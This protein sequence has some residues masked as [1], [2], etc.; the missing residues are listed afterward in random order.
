MPGAFAETEVKVSA[1]DEG[2]RA[3]HRD[4]NLSDVVRHIRDDGPAAVDTEIAESAAGASQS[5]G[6]QSRPKSAAPDSPP[7]ILVEPLSGGAARTSGR[8]GM[9]VAASAAVVVVL[10]GL[11]LFFAG[12][13]VDI[14][15]STASERTAP[16]APADQH[17]PR[18]VAVSEAS[19]AIAAI[20]REDHER[21]RQL[22]ALVAQGNQADKARIAE[23]EE[24]VKQAQAALAA[25]SHRLELVAR[26]PKDEASVGPDTAKPIAP[27]VAANGSPSRHAGAVQQ[28][29]RGGPTRGNAAQPQPDALTSAVRSIAA[30][31]KRRIAQALAK[32]ADS[33]SSGRARDTEPA[34]PA[35]AVAPPGSAPYGAET[36]VVSAA[37]GDN[38]PAISK[39]EP[40]GTHTGGAIEGGGEPS[41]I[42]AS[43]FDRP[44]PTEQAH[45][46]PA[47]H[48]L[49][50]AAAEAMGFAVPKQD[51]SGTGEALGTAGLALAEPPSALQHKAA[52]PPESSRH[53]LPAKASTHASAK[54]GRLVT[55]SGPKQAR[56]PL[57]SR[58]ADAPTDRAGHGTWAINL[59]AVSTRERAEAA[60]RV[61]RE[62]GCTTEI[63]VLRRHGSQAT[64]FGVGIPGFGTR[65][66]A[67][68]QV[69]TVKT[70]LGIKTVWVHQEK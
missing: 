14:F 42:H 43:S 4:L 34:A 2:S 52:V 53:S 16:G 70:K 58:P 26:R 25:L 9:A 49:Q 38:I 21:V 51:A 20:A 23:L 46:E 56:S 40:V 13:D 6:A 11:A 35:Q 57:T 39:D 27:E 24:R 65:E 33:P 55:A 19:P 47:V 15:P 44:K 45:P 59:I 28:P 69:P 8:R 1:H 48:E 31:G 63:V 67:F 66:E 29:Q 3:E 36:A 54:S 10:I 62:K 32:S 64:L 37:R 17:S 18:G 50:T 68:A 5:E 41:R 12:A 7:Q 61:Y 22:K 60:Q 30:Q